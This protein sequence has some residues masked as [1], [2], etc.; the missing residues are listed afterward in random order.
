MGSW[1]TDIFSNDTSADVRDEYRELLSAGVE[2]AEATRLLAEDHADDIADPDVAADFWL[3]LAAAQWE[4]G[5]MEAPKRT[6]ALELIESG[7]DLRR[8]RDLGGDDAD[9]EER[10][11]RLEIL[12][13]RLAGP[14]PRRV[15]IPTRS[16]AD[17]RMPSPASFDVGE[18]FSY[19]L[20]SGKKVVLRVVDQVEDRAGASPSV[21]LLDWIGDSPP[22]VEVLRRLPI[23][24]GRR[25]GE[26]FRAIYMLVDE[27]GDRCPDERTEIV[28]RDWGRLVLMEVEEQYEDLIRW[29]M[30]E[31]ELEVRFGLR[32]DP[33][34]SPF[35]YSLEYETK[36]AAD[37][38]VA[39]LRAQGFN[40]TLEGPAGS[41]G[42]GWTVGVESEVES[43]DA[44]RRLQRYADAT[45]ALLDLP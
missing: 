33:E 29:S 30:L 26:T 41:L 40:T 27:P 35:N 7:S 23:R 16:P 12:E 2:D 5:R 44:E 38:A 15:E 19:A 3:G 20:E 39:A 8:W 32:P 14:P 43:R 9:L 21:A 28:A 13:A 36:A 4:M 45:D 6:K 10:R 25:E 18:V 37:K 17:T 31:E 42:E 34:D 1:G 11:E 22:P 24:E